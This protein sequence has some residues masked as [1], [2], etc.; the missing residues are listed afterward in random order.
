MT[1]PL[2]NP[3]IDQPH[4]VR[5]GE[6]LDLEKLDAY[7]REHLGGDGTPPIVFQYRHGYSNLTYRVVF[8]GRDMVL[9][10]PPVG[11]HVKSG[12][13]MQ[14]EFRVLTA[15]SP[16]YA[17]APKPILFCD[18][19][20]VLGA[21]FYLM[22]RVQGVILRAPLPEHLTIPPDLMRRIASA[23]VENFVAIHA[24]EWQKEPLVQ[25]GRPEGYVE[26]QVNGWLQRYAAAKT[27]D[28]PDVEATGAWIAS[29]MPAQ[30]ATALIHNDYKYDNIVLS[31][32]DLAAIRAVL[33]WEMATLGDPLM[34]LGTSL[35][36]WVDPDDPPEMMML[37]SLSGVTALPG[38]FSR[39]EVVQHYATASGRDVGAILFYYVYG[40]FKN[41][42][43]AQQIYARYK[44]GS[45]NDERFGQLLP[46]IRLMGQFAMQA[47]AHHRIDRLG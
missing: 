3:P 23:V 36:Y 40:L 1:D 16:I 21:P 7:L 28:L 20:A 33:D 13:D 39:A 27:D 17:K 5:P 47:V 15:L 37:S 26:R 30:S 42:V 11:A 31:P 35:A 34:D 43:I 32:D 38:N 12:H 25:L 44:Q 8:G 4:P 22:E 14:R 41:A 18:D 10:R 45:T 6:E 46:A 29:H 19:L 2:M 9:R 24:L